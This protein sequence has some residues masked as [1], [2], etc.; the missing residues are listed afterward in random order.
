MDSDPLGT[1][2]SAV[3]QHRDLRVSRNDRIFLYSD[4]LIEASPGASRRVG[5]QS[6]TEACV[7]HRGKPLAEAVTLIARELK[8]E[9][10]TVEDD[11]LLLATEVTE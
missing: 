5:V 7:R 11:L 3:L 2:S 6:L 1:F 9:T 4:G 8:P 10:E